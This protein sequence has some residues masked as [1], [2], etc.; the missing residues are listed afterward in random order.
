MKYLSWKRMHFPEHRQIFVRL[1]KNTKIS[2]VAN[3]RRRLRLNMRRLFNW[4]AGG[5]QNASDLPNSPADGDFTLAVTEISE[6]RRFFIGLFAAGMFL[7]IF[8]SAFVEKSYCGNAVS[9]SASDESQKDESVDSTMQS[10]IKALRQGDSDER[11]RAAIALSTSG[12][13]SAVEPLIQALNDKDDFVRDFAVRGLGNLHDPRAV[14]P[15]IKALGDKNLLVK[16]SAARA[17]GA[18]GDPRAVEPLIKALDDDDVLVKRSAIRALGNLRDLKAIDPLINSLGESDVYLS[19]AAA[20]A[21]V[22]AGDLAIPRLVASLADWTLGPKA[23]EVLQTLGWKPSSSEEKVRFDVAQRNRQA[24]LAQW[25]IA[26]K[27]LLDDASSDNIRQVQNAVFAFISI[28]RDQIIGD[29]IKLLAEKGDGKM[30]KAYSDCGNASLAEAARSWAKNHGVDLNSFQNESI[31]VEW[32][33]MG[34]SQTASE[35]LSS[36]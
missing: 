35:T 20:T 34:S 1:N 7:L 10:L 12:N 30:A 24:L 27:I 14:E 36:L 4:I 17:L 25:E 29:L 18:I 3:E 23:A 22:D 15:L 11:Q 31:V 32:G 8:Q 13:A 28:G 33:K 21:L 26:Q 5:L 6:S 16:R 19:N 2:P 9:I